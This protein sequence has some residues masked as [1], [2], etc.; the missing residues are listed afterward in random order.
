M[1][2][3]VVYFRSNRLSSDNLSQFKNILVL[4]TALRNCLLRLWI[5]KDELNLAMFTYVVVL[6]I[7]IEKVK[8]Y[9]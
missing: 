7:L 5:Y 3:V 2:I 4:L 1:F 9:S 6:P 8:Q